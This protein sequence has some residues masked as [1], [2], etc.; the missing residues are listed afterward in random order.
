MGLISIVHSLFIYFFRNSL[1][2]DILIGISSFYYIIDILNYVNKI[3]FF[4][5]LF[6][7]YAFLYCLGNVELEELM[8]KI[9]VVEGSV[10]FLN[11]YLMI[12]TPLVNPIKRLVFVFYLFSHVY[13]RNVVLTRL[14]VE[15]LN[16]LEKKSNILFLIF[17]CMNFWW[18]YRCI[19][20]IKKFIPIFVTRN[21][22][23]NTT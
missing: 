15:N 5:H 13:F 16:I 14:Y 10:P 1:P 9:L 18:T 6:S 4:H 2:Y 3:Y 23:D 8:R 7:I 17:I 19:V 21:S 11:L 22:L 20:K 12:E